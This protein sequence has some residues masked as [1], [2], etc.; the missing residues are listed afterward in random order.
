[1]PCLTLTQ[2]LD[3]RYVLGVGRSGEEFRG[4]LVR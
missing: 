3:T 2:G 4:R 1:M